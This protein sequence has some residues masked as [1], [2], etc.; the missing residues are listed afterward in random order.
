M[1]TSIKYLI[2]EVLP[3]ILRGDDFVMEK[4]GNSRHG[5][6]FGSRIGQWNN[7]HNFNSYLNFALSPD[8]VLIENS[9]F[10]VKNEV[11]KS[12]HWEEHIWK[13]GQT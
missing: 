10:P 3:W 7:K 6:H 13:D 4:E 8:L 9:W 5:L 1:L 11:R 12:L 2:P